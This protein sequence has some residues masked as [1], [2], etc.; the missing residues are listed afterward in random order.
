MTYLEALQWLDAR[1]YNCLLIPG[2]TVDYCSKASNYEPLANEIKREKA[3][4]REGQYFIEFFRNAKGDVLPKL[5]EYPR[6]ESMTSDISMNAEAPS[7]LPPERQVENVRAG[8]PGYYEAPHV[9]VGLRVKTVTVSPATGFVLSV[10]K[11]PLPS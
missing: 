6:P 10:E 1:G 7:A 4:P 5:Y 11:E 8:H 3:S 9:A 2:W